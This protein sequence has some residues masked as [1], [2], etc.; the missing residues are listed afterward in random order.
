MG[1][2]ILFPHLVLSGILIRTIDLAELF[3][4]F[5]PRGLPLWGNRSVVCNGVQAA[6][7]FHRVLVW[8]WRLVWCLLW[9]RLQ[10]LLVCATFSDVVV[11]QLMPFPKNGRPLKVFSGIVLNAPCRTRLLY[12]KKLC[13]FATQIKWF[14]W[15]CWIA[16]R[17][18][19][20]EFESTD[21]NNTVLI[22]GTNQS[23]N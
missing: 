16:E 20:S 3:Q 1:Y 11:V 14:S 7:L 23:Y 5:F 17:I 9:L 19:L 21:Y 8:V 18:T 22:R 12:D 6:G 13:W 4:I 10:F 2:S 15:L